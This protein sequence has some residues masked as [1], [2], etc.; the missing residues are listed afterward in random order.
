MRAAGGLLDAGVATS[1]GASDFVITLPCDNRV[2]VPGVL[3]GVT[4]QDAPA[5]EMT[6]ELKRSYRAAASKMAAS[7]AKDTYADVFAITSSA[8]SVGAIVTSFL[9]RSVLMSG[10][11]LALG[12]A[13]LIWGEDK[14]YSV[15]LLTTCL[16]FL[17][18][19]STAYVTYRYFY[20]SEEMVYVQ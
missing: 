12:G 16:F 20:P 1:A 17:A 18:L 3:P 15:G 2:V 6:A 7:S 14:G 11:L 9:A 13:V 4:T 10:A 5:P 8:A 19:A